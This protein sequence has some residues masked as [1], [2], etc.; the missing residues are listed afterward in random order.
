MTTDLE[1]F[2][3]VKNHLLTQNEKS[4]TTYSGCSYFYIPD[5]D[6][7][8]IE[9]EAMRNSIDDMDC[10]ETFKL[11]YKDAIASHIEN[12]TGPVLSCA[13]GC[14]IDYKFYDYEAEGKSAN[15]DYV[16]DM[17]KPSLPDWEIGND[18]IMMLRV[19]QNIHDGFEPEEWR[20]MFDL[21]EKDN[22][23]N[24][25]QEFHLGA[26]KYNPAESSDP[27]SYYPNQVYMRLITR[28][29]EDAI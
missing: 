15:S 7:E 14:L 25:H 4:E 5:L 19:L 1:V 23:F 12:K 8:E 20:D 10:N 2:N 6:I 13:V 18:Q 11:Y 24:E 27:S 17:I 21:M 26:D 3:R 16:L 29:D 22:L 28:G 9:Q